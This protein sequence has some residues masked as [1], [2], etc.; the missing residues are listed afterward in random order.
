VEISGNAREGL[1]LTVNGDSQASIE[2]RD[3]MVS[4]N[5]GIGLRLVT[6]GAA[7]TSFSLS[8]SILEENLG[9]AVQLDYGGSGSGTFTISD[10]P[11]ISSLGSSGVRVFVS[12]GAD[13]FIQGRIERNTITS[14]DPATA[15]NG[16]AVINEGD[17]TAVVMVA[18][19]IAHNFGSYGID[20]GSRGGAGVLEATVEGNTVADPAA[21]ALA[22]MRLSAGNGTPGESSTLCLDLQGNTTVTGELPGYLQR[23][24]PGASFHL[25][26]FAGQDSSAGVVESFVTSRNT[27]SVSVS[28]AGSGYAAGGCRTPS[29]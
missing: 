16:V 20:V 5:Q 15:G 13:Q 9:N 22:G 26:G 7:T 10:N 25:N 24:R 11:S 4:R 17:A 23:Q 14:S 28:A 29:F 3:V 12:G 8:G 27:G 1:L 19:N 2:L 18:D 21:F 6:G